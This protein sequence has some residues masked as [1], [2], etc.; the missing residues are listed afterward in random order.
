MQHTF[1]AS[2]MRKVLCVNTQ[3]NKLQESLKL[4]QGFGEKRMKIISFI[5]QTDNLHERM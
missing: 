2:I 3:N 1:C 5:G 4:L